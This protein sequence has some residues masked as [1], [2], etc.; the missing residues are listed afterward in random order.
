MTN[1]KKTDSC[2]ELFKTMS[3]LPFYSQYI[4]SCLLYV[5]NNQ[6]LFKELRGP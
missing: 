2:T 4:F 3:I 6:H 5:V 1:L